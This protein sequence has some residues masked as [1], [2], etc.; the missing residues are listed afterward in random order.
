MNNLLFKGVC[1]ESQVNS[2]FE[3]RHSTFELALRLTAECRHTILLALRTSYLGTTMVLPGIRREIVH[4]L[5]A[6]VVA[7]G[8]LPFGR[9]PQGLLIPRSLQIFRQS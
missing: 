7:V 3:N 2:T 4:K 9:R 5:F 8:R 6:R 1:F